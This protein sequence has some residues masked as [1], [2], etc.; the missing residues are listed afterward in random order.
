[1]ADTVKNLNKKPTKVTTCQSPC[2]VQNEAGAL[3]FLWKFFVNIDSNI[4]S[5]EGDVLRIVLEKNLK[6]S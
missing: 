4:V 6:N 2:F 5:C 1:M 3:L